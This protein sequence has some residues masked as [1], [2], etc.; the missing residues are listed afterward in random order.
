MAKSKKSRQIPKEQSVEKDVPN[1]IC[2][3]GLKT[4]GFVVGF[5]EILMCILAIYGLFRNFHLFGMSYFFWFIVG[6]ISVII[7]LIAIAV[8]FYAIKAEKPR[9]LLPHLSAQIFLIL[10]MFIVVLVVAILLLF[11]AY[12]GIR[13]LLGH[14]DFH[15]SDSSTL[16]LGI[17]IIIVYLAVAFLEIFFLYI[18]YKLYKYLKGYKLM[19]ERKH[20][21]RTGNAAYNS[22]DW[23]IAPE[24]QRAYG[25]S[26]DA[27]DVYP[28][29]APLINSRE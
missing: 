10:F 19:E 16:T 13:R 28:Y 11:G 2:C 4:A 21:W 1:R 29:E 14:G 20:D 26:P 8:L 9:W 5:V 7:I 17:W 23:F 12:R 22:N 27:G 3:C 15:M 6:L 18:I 24:N 25:G